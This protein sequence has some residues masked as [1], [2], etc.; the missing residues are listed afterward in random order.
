M[1]PRVSKLPIVR[2]A[3][4]K[5]DGFF[6]EL[7]LRVNAYFD[8]KKIETRG[9][10]KMKWKTI[11]MLSMYF[12]PFIVLMVFARD[13]HPALSL[14][15]WFG[16]GI[17]MVGIGTSVMHD[18]NHG[19]YFESKLMNKAM[20]NVI[21]L[22]GGY[23]PTWK[24]QHNIL[25]HTYTNIEGLDGD[26]E[27]GAVLRFHPHGER[28][29]WH[30]YQHY[31]AWFLYGLLTLQ[32]CTIKDYRSVIG[33]NKVDLLKKEK[34][35]L[36]KAIIQITVSKIL[37]FTAFIVLPILFSGLPWGYIVGG[38]VLMHFVAGLSLSAIF[39]LAHVMEGSEF[40]KPSVE[41]KMENN[42]AVHQIKNTLNFSPRSRI[43]SW[44]IGGLNY[45]IEHHL[46]PHI[47]HVHYPQLSHIVR[48]TATKYGIPYQVVPTFIGALAEH[49][50]MLKKLGR[51]D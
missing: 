7:K 16:M 29:K 44:F 35:T 14:L 33:Y 37:Y 21:N 38:F 25:H 22:L 45:Q 47:C 51:E 18:S 40:P 15:C 2:F 49:G 12:V 4:R 23:S 28:F 26:L 48:R 1:P 19:S 9:N 50:R 17:G 27:A 41:R 24:I 46:F 3:S 8:N 11:A 6:D 36:R 30:A 32:W 42:W 39:Q 13:F 5:Q 31:Y 20:G 34:L 43:L 10:S